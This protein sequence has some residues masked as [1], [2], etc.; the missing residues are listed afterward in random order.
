[1]KN[2]IEELQRRPWPGNVRELANAVERAVILTRSGPL[3]LEAFGAA[4]VTRDLG[5]AVAL[6]NRFAPEHLELMVEDPQRLLPEIK[7]AGAV[8][9]GMYT[10][11]ALGDYMAGPNHVLPTGGTARFASPLGVYD[12]VKRTSVL[13]FSQKGLERYAKTA[14]RL[15]EILAAARTPRH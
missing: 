4:V 3:G 11:E 8:F 6:A 7:N 14:V 10:P 5:E 15:A 13:S 1:M 12:F 2:R 9:L